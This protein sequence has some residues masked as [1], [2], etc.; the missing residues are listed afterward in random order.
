[1][2]RT[3]EQLQ[4]LNETLRTGVSSED[5]EMIRLS[6]EKGCDPDFY[7][8]TAHARGTL[9][10]QKPDLLRLALKKGA[11]AELVLFA[12][13]ERRSLALVKIAVEDGHASVTSSHAGPGK[14][15]VYPIA[16]WSYRN[17]DAPVSDYLMGKGMDVDMPSTDGTTSLLRAVTD[18]RYDRTMHYLGHGANPFAA[19]A[20][21]IFPLQAAEQ[22]RG[23]S[24]DT[25]IEKK[26]EILRAM[27]KNVPEGQPAPAA[28]PSKAFNSVATSHDI[29]VRPFELKKPPAED[30]P[31]Q[32]KPVKGFQL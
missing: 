23:S 27:L 28:E 18:Q 30:P 5:D 8:T 14:T 21:G 25:F 16:E 22:A 4:A 19:N 7:I 24:Y 20:K 15:D 31:P 9:E 3:P 26:N 29:S 13:I 10:K 6:L 2:K 32:G 12:G 1:M 11:D 17:F